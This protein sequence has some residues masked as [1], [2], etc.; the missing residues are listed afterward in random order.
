MPVSESIVAAVAAGAGAGSSVFA[1]NYVQPSNQP[2]PPP[3]ELRG[4]KVKQGKTYHQFFFD[5]LK[6]SLVQASVGLLLVGSACRAIFLSEHDFVVWSATAQEVYEATVVPNCFP[7]GQDNYKMVMAACPDVSA[8]NV[9]NTSLGFPSMFSPFLSTFVG[10]KVG[11]TIEIYQWEEHKQTSCETTADAGQTC[12]DYFTYSK[13]WRM[14]PVDSKKF[15]I[16]GNLNHDTEL[17]MNVASGIVHAAIGSVVIWNAS[18]QPVAPLAQ[19]IGFVLDWKMQEAMPKTRI[20]WKAR[21]KSNKTKWPK[22]GE[23]SA[24]MLHSNG[25]DFL[26]TFTGQPEIGDLRISATGC[27]NGEVTVVA[28]QRPLQEELH[29]YTLEPVS[30]KVY[31]IFGGLTN[32]L[33]KV[34]G[35]IL[36]EDEF[37]EHFK[38]ENWDAV[39][40]RR[41]L[42]IT[43]MITGC[44][45]MTAPCSAA[46]RIFSLLD[47]FAVVQEYLPGVG[48]FLADSAQMVM[49][50][51]GAVLGL[52]T[53]FCVW[54][55]VYSALHPGLAAAFFG[56]VLS[57]WCC[58]CYC[59]ATLHKLHRAETRLSAKV[60]HL[61]ERMLGDA[62]K[63]AE[64]TA[65]CAMPSVFCWGHL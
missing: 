47:N 27:A 7:R 32:P 61:E 45:A 40:K 44:I 25:G 55:V 21:A 26:H 50:I 6:S 20:H 39:W 53:F 24:E 30:P 35:G 46:A 49:A 33:E 60:E 22:K 54:F 65:Y 28:K 64:T 62:D 14:E 37:L 3:P 1:T 2:V 41:M 63:V 4:E 8:P 51:V 31:N 17:P 16:G 36:S 18:A 59:T 13:D 15:N 42:L 5:I 23:L 48:G 56:L 58:G 34:Y 43:A 38:S 52:V 19:P 12:T 29:L 9:A 10:S 57:T 11:W